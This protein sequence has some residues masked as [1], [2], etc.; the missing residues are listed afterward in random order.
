MNDLNVI[1]VNVRG[2]NSYQKRNKLFA[3]FTESKFDIIFLQETHF[4]VD[5]DNRDN[6]S[7]NWS[8]GIFHALSDSSHSRGVTILFRK[9]LDIDVI[10]IHR[11]DDGR[12]S[13]FKHQ[14]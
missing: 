6:Y 4:K 10:D 13:T 2:I 9:D 5:P 12:R 8:G 3:W 7:Y 1:T 11:S 14:N